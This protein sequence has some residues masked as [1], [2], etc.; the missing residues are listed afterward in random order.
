MDRVRRHRHLLLVNLRGLQG[1]LLPVS[2][3]VVD[4]VLRLVLGE[5]AAVLGGELIEDALL[6]HVQ[7]VRVGLGGLQ[8]VLVPVRIDVV[9]RVLRGL[10]RELI[11][12]RGEL[13]EDRL[14]RHVHQIRVRLGRGQRRGELSRHILR[15]SLFLSLLGRR[16]LVDG[17]VLD[18]LVRSGL[19]G[20]GL[21]LG[22]RLR[23]RRVIGAVAAADH[24]HRAAAED[25]DRQ[26]R[27][28]AAAQGDE[29]ALAT[30]LGGGRG[31]LPGSSTVRGGRGLV[32]CGVV[33]GLVL[34]LRVRGGHEHSCL[35]SRAHEDAPWGREKQ[36]K[37]WRRRQI[38]PVCRT[39]VLRR[40]SACPREERRVIPSSSTGGTDDAGTPC[41][42]G[43]TCPFSTVA[44]KVWGPT[45]CGRQGRDD[46]P[47]PNPRLPPAAPRRTVA[48][49]AYPRG[50]RRRAPPGTCPGGRCACRWS[51]PR[52]AP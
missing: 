1:V 16:L 39:A 52:P 40:R 37:G 35:G 2:V 46:V 4:R 9:D 41:G 5:L 23:G 45:S 22:D 32:G 47:T 33:L 49:P 8:R 43:D 14:L 6:R 20:G 18:G 26:Q 13:I 27:E 50:T 19:L 12:L 36:P 48:V 15:S 34:P 42:D 10:L 3:D 25:Q 38:E 44:R 7:R 30:L 29:L 11:E 51:P 24:Q 31:G 28:K 17:L 21:L